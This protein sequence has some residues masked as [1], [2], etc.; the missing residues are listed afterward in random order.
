MWFKLDFLVTFFCAYLVLYRENEWEEK[1][2]VKFE[3]W[4]NKENKI[5]RRPVFDTRM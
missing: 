5:L 4:Q 3:F 1:W 2:T